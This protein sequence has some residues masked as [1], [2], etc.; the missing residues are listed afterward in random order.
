MQG[1][2]KKKEK[3]KKH[4][5]LELNDTALHYEKLMVTIDFGGKQQYCKF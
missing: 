4:P 1:A 2:E 3:K 5:S